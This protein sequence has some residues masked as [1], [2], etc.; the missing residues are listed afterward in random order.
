MGISKGKGSSFKFQCFFRC[1]YH[2]TSNQICLISVLQNKREKLQLCKSPRCISIFL[3]VPSNNN[4]A[5]G[6][7]MADVVVSTLCRAYN[8]NWSLKHL[9]C[10]IAILCELRLFTQPDHTIKMWNMSKSFFWV[11]LKCSS[12]FNSMFIKRGSCL[13]Y[14]NLLLHLNMLASRTR[15]YGPCKGT[16]NMKYYCQVGKLI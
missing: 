9:D 5:P 3:N 10:W 15:L 4:V 7:H 1:K 12:F 2:I 16:K 13:V 14:E 11:N 6:Y 8:V